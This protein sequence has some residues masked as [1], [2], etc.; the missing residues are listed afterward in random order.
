MLKLLIACFQVHHAS[1]NFKYSKLIKKQVKKPLAVVL[2]E[3]LFLDV[4]DLL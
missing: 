1:N 2:F 3:F 4:W